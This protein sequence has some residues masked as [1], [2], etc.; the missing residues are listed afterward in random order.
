MLR[1]SIPTWP[2][3][4][5]K[6]FALIREVMS[7]IYVER[8]AHDGHWEIATKIAQTYD[9]HGNMIQRRLR[10][11]LK[12][13]GI[14]VRSEEPV[15]LRWEDKGFVRLILRSIV[16]SGVCASHTPKCKTAI[17]KA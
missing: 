11:A 14:F 2:T 8:R 3:I 16:E 9:G 10:Q 4:H 17:G 12:R 6:I 13:G 5:D 1:E 7:P 15:L